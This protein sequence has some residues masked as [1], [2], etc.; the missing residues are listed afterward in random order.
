M[1]QN[2]AREARPNLYFGLNAPDGTEVFPIRSDG[3]DGNWR[4]SKKKIESEE[5]RIEWVKG[6]NG[7]T[8]YYKIYADE[9]MERPPETIWY[10]K[11]VGSNRN[12]IVEIKDIFTN[13]KSF[14]TPKPTQLIERI[15]QIATDKDSIVLDSFAGSGTTAHAVLNL[16]KADGGNRTFILVEMMDYADTITAE[17]VKRVIDGYGEGN[18][19]TEGT[20]GDF[21]F[22]EVGEAL[23]SDGVLNENVDE[24][25]IRAY[26]WYTETRTPYRKPTNGSPAFL[27]CAE[28]TAYYFHYEKGA[29]TT[30]DSAFLK[31][32]AEKAERYVIYADLCV[33]P[34]EMM[35]KYHIEFRKIPRDI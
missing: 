29:A 17:R 28:G 8:V 34:P 19:K 25:K 24:K 13:E 27:G 35:E 11:E 2:D 5:E 20:G 12:S 31:D 23:F 10:N 30:L 15:L 6:K 21:S 9:Q 7:W 1:G 3:S 33:L 14:D 4:W 32:V 22:Y 16:N 26:I 18:K